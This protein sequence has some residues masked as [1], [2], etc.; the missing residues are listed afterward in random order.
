MSA[1]K[2]E[3]AIGTL[4]SEAKKMAQL[5]TSSARS[6]TAVSLTLA[7]ENLAKA[8]AV[9]IEARRGDICPICKKRR[10]DWRDYMAGTTG[11][12]S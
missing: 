4:L 5:A 1:D 3:T 9:L 6:E 8:A 7:A 2:T 10:Q 11:D 12:P